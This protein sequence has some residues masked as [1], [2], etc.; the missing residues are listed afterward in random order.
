MSEPK[1]KTPEDVIH[2]AI[3]SDEPLYVLLSDHQKEITK[4]KHFNDQHLTTIE[5]LAKKNVDL[6]DKVEVYR[7][8]LEWIDENEPE[9]SFEMFQKKFV[10]VFGDE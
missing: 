8:W 10:E 3:A 9:I 5:W 1:T 4:L 2:E 7:K 6:K